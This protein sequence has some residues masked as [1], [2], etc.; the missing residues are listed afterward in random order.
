METRTLFIARHQKPLHAEGK[1]PAPP[2]APPCPATVTAAGGGGGGGGGRRVLR[3]C[4]VPDALQ[5]PL[6]LHLGV[7]EREMSG[8]V[9]GGAWVRV[10]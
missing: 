6:V 2:R 1:R 9:A 4:A 8:R 5:A 3:L 10:G 7:Y